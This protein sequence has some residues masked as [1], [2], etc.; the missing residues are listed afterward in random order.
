VNLIKV[1]DNYK[2]NLPSEEKTKIEND[3]AN[4]NI[5]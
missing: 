5:R 2:A 4:S 1:K 3:R